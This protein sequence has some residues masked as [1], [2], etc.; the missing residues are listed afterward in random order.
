MPLNIWIPFPALLQFE[1]DAEQSLL[2]F[3]S[4]MEVALYVLS[5]MWI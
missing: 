2:Q 4:E 3:C 1:C 5:V